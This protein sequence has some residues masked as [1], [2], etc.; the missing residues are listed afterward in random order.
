[1]SLP[2]S[3]CKK[4]ADEYGHDQVI[5]LTWRRSDGKS[6]VATYGK[7][8]VD[9]LQAAEGATLL[10]RAMQWPEPQCDKMPAWVE[11]L[12]SRVKELEDELA[13]LKWKWEE[14]S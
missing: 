8:K 3:A 5:V 9:C 12:K 7:T 10:K 6:W 1:M 2:V 13:E 4:I 11:K 14:L